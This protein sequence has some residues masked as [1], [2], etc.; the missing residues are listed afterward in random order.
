MRQPCIPV[1]NPEKYAHEGRLVSEARRFPRPRSGSNVTP[2]RARP[3]LAGPKPHTRLSF[4]FRSEAGASRRAGN[5]GKKKK[6]KNA[7]AAKKN[8]AVQLPRLPR[9]LRRASRPGNAGAQPGP[10]KTPGKEVPQGKAS[11]SRR[12]RPGKGCSVLG[13]GQ[14]GQTDQ[15][16]P[17]PGKIEPSSLTDQPVPA[18]EAS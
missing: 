17:K 11:L 8:A 16:F 4:P 7:A 10:T 5:T 18:R 2:R 15:H 9:L 1:C 13:R 14:T 12:G 6:T 3:G